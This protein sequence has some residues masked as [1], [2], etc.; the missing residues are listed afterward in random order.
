M[1]KEYLY[2]Q[3]DISQDDIG[4]PMI[5]MTD[6]SDMNMAVELMQHGAYYFIDISLGKNY[7]SRYLESKK[8]MARAIGFE[9]YKLN[10]V[11]I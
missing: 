3:K 11:L 2:L 7:S 6:H 9:L 1:L 10:L 4:L 5:F 8:P